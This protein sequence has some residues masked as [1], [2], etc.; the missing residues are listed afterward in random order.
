MSKIAFLVSLVIFILMCLFKG[1]PCLWN[2]TKQTATGNRRFMEGNKTYERRVRTKEKTKN[3]YDL[4]SMPSGIDTKEGR[5][6][7]KDHRASA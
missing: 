6:A 7:R 4:G 2:R 5:R 3:G 1:W